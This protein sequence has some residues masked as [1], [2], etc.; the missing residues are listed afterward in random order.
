MKSYSNTDLPR[1]LDRAEFSPRL[2]ETAPKLSESLVNGRKL[3]VKLGLA[4][5][6]A[7]KQKM[8]QFHV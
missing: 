4:S 7:V 6:L 3:F 8:R 1:P 2:A 5:E